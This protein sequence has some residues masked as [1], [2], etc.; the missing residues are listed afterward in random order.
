MKSCREGMLLHALAILA[1]CMLILIAGCIQ[2]TNTS[3]AG[4][5]TSGGTQYVS[6]GSAVP[7]TATETPGPGGN[8]EAAASPANT[9]PGETPAPA[10][11]PAGVSVQ[12]TT[13][14]SSYDRDHRWVIVRVNDDDTYTVGQI[15]YDRDAKVWFRVEEERLVIR[16]IH[17]VER[18]YPVL[19]GNVS[20]GQLPV[21]HGVMDQFGVTKLVW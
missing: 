5:G 14:D 6:Q 7:V 1:A 10:L 2:P 11:Y 15:Y 8:V 17:A 18:D 13:S 3:N 12:K 4:P 19:V 21:K 16:S 9:T 20:W